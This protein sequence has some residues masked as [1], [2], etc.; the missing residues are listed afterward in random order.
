MNEA[1]RTSLSRLWVLMVTAFVDMIG[2]SLIL[3]LLPYYALEYGGTPAMVGWLLAVYALAQ[4]IAAPQWGRIS[5]R[6]GRRP[7]I[8]GGQ[9]MAAVAFVV[10]AFADSVW[11]LFISR[12]FQ[13]IGTGTI[14]VISAYVSDAV[15][16]EKRAQGLGWITACTSAGV[17]IGP[18]I[19]SF[20]VQW[21]NAMPGLLAAGFCILNIV[22]AFIWLPESRPDRDGKSPR[23]LI[24]AISAVLAKPLDVTSILIWVY[25]IGMMAF[26]AMNGVFALY[27]D[28]KFG[29]TKEQI[30]YFFVFVGAAS[31][32]M[33]ALVLGKLVDLFG[34]VRVLRLGATILGL[35][36]VFA[37]IAPSVWVFFIAMLF[38][39]TGTSLL[40]PCTTSL[41][42][43]Y[44]DPDELGQTLGVQQSFGGI[45]R[46]VGPIWAAWIFE[47]I[48]IAEPFIVAGVL[49][50]IALGVAV[51]RLSPGD[52]PEPR[53]K[54]AEVE[55]AVS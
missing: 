20:S 5:D 28:E 46:M 14:A 3:P 32:I 29:I 42:S 45:S 30:G 16:P 13:G 40:F 9:M 36:L 15:P 4:L 12:I 33:R 51:A 6:F 48:G 25:A 39:P 47:A 8:I 10:F 41:I 50:F 43:R 53:L 27:L 22:F 7:V 1:N 44:A 21:G 34:E 11:L 23:R 37:A 49:M 24:H 17:M 38:V 55:Q 2:F 54:E 26:M 19:G 18:A 52:A 35:G 31:V